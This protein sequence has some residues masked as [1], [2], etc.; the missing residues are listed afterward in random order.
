[1]KRKILLVVCVV[2]LIGFILEVK[3]TY[4]LFETNGGAIVSKKLAKWQ[5]K[6]NNTYLT[7]LSEDRNTF[8]LGSIEW[9]N[10]DHVK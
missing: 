5:I 10:V 6:V 4:S 1:M 8:S 3:S 2:V 7:T 9:E